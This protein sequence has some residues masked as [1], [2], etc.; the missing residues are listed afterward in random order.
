LLQY[1][2]GVDVAKEIDDTFGPRLR[3][4]GQQ[5]E[6]PYYD[7]FVVHMFAYILHQEQR[8]KFR[9]T[10]MLTDGQLFAKKDML[11]RTKKWH[12]PRDPLVVRIARGWYVHWVDRTTFQ[13]GW[14]KC[15][16]AFEV[17]LMWLQVLVLNHDGELTTA[18][19]LG[20]WAKQFI[21]L[22]PPPVSVAEDDECMW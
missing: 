14:I 21:D 12:M 19:K 20:P 6:H 13:A 22:A 8:V 1:E 11:F 2:L 16:D 5:P 15:A 4:I 7:L 18:F 9:E 17:C 10:L 3:H